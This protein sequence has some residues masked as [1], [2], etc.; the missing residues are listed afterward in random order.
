MM[1]AQSE[2]IDTHQCAS[3][4]GWTYQALRESRSKN[5]KKRGY[6]STPPYTKTATGLIRYKL[7]DVVRWMATSGYVNGYK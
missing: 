1:M 7:S 6:K 3:K 2:Y 4:I 5:A